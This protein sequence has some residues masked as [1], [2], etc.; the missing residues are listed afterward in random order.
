MRRDDPFSL[1]LV[2]VISSMSRGTRIGG[3]A[4]RLVR[5]PRHNTDWRDNENRVRCRRLYGRY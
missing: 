5:V 4:A 2:K 1:L 3:A